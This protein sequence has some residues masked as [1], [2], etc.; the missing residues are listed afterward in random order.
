MATDQWQGC[1]PPAWSGSIQ[2]TP[3]NKQAS[4]INSCAASHCLWTVR[5]SNVT[6]QGTITYTL[7]GVSFTNS[8]TG[9]GGLNASFTFYKLQ[10]APM[11]PSS[12]Q[13]IGINQASAPPG[14][15]ATAGAGQF[16]GPVVGYQVEDVPSGPNGHKRGTATLQLPVTPQVLNVLE[17]PDPL[18]ITIATT[19]GRSV[20]TLGAVSMASVTLGSTLATMHLTFNYYNVK[21][22][23]YTGAS[24]VPTQSVGWDYYTGQPMQ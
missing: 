4:Q 6:A 5:L 3:T 11:V 21:Y 20:Y 13:A 23:T 2:F 22:A 18:T 16:L 12:V 17:G 7:S 9:A 8:G 19:Q 10:W 1:H 15:T 24:T 14:V